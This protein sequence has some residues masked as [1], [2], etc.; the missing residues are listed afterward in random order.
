MTRHRTAA[1]HR[2]E[3][4]GRERRVLGKHGEEERHERARQIGGGLSVYIYVQIH[5]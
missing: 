4:R 3:R 2:E 5:I 1:V